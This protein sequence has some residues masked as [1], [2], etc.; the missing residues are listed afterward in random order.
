MDRG[1][2]SVTL[3]VGNCRFYTVLRGS[4]F[5]IDVHCRSMGR[6]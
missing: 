6:K 4:Q 3:D 1:P 2:A 5:P